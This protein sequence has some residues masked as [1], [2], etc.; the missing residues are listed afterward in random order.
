MPAARQTALESVQDAK[1]AI[2][3]SGNWIKNADTKSTVIAAATGVVASA[4]ASRADTVHKAFTEGRLG[5]AGPIVTLL[6][7]SY[8]A[9]LTVTVLHLYRALAP[10][11]RPLNASNRFAWPSVELC[12][13]EVPDSNWAI[14]QDE[15]WSQNY[16]L[17]CIAGAKYRALKRAL[18]WF[19]GS[20]ALAI[21]IT[22]VATW[23]TSATP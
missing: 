2:Q 21:A 12:G 1:F 22:C 23:A 6:I 13:R 9:T 15:A 17:A 3:E 16:M 11:T 14:V 7:L 4:L 18:G 19:G 10:R 5:C 8:I 20:L